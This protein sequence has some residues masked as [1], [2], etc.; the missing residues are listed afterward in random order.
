MLLNK[1]TKMNKYCLQISIF[2][3]AITLLTACK[4]K[5]LGVKDYAEKKEVRDLFQKTP[6]FETLNSQIQI[7]TNGLSA[8]GDLRMIKNQVIYLSVQ[9][10]L[11]IEVAR[12]KITPDSLIAIDRLHR[13]Y[14]AD[15]FAQ[16]NGLSTKG[17]SFYTIQSL[18]TNS[19]FLTDRD[20]LS[21]ADISEFV[22][23]RK[24]AETNLSP[25]KDE[26]FQFI[27][28]QDKQLRQTSLTMD[29]FIMLWNYSQFSQAAGYTFPRN[30][31]VE[32]ATEKRKTNLS[33]EFAKIDL[34]KSLKVDCQIPQRYSKVDLSEILTLLSGL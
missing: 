15:S 31:E 23:E 5:M 10:F 19:L 12:L 11:G 9:A 33:L 21:L 7:S 8:K 30:M 1:I 27:L 3:L 25:R 18:F 24:G 14:F 2:L 16:I 22:W 20:S 13:R 4:S 28:N 6:R 17:L 34:G 29:K 32:M 26:K